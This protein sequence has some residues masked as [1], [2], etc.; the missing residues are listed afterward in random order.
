LKFRSKDPHQ[1]TEGPAQFAS[2]KESETDIQ[3]GCLLYT[4]WERETRNASHPIP[5]ARMGI[6]QGEHHIANIDST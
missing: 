2:A 6:Q 1:S 5:T 4:Q 3:R